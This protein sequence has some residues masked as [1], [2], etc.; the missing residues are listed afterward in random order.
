MFVL[1]S[2]TSANPY[3]IKQDYLLAI[4][5]ADYFT[6]VTDDEGDDTPS[7]LWPNTRTPRFKTSVKSEP[8]EAAAVELAEVLPTDSTTT[9]GATR[10]PQDRRMRALT[11][12]ERACLAPTA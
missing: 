3:R 7:G 2:T 9:K 5:P 1:V 10:P 12:D 11:P 8:A 6:E 4:G